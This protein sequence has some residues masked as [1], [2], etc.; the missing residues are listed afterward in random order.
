MMTKKRINLADHLK[1]VRLEKVQILEWAMELCLGMVQA[2]AQ[3]IECYRD[4]KPANILI[5]PERVL[6]IG[7]FGLSLAK[8]AALRAANIRFLKVTE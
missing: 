7:D 1:G 3:D 2:R 5:S 4:L 8:E 6:K